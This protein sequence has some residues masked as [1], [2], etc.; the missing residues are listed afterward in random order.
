MTSD[1]VS[2]Q[3]RDD[4]RFLGDNL[5]AVLKSLEGQELFELVEKVRALS[6][7]ARA[8]NAHD[9]KLL[10]GLLASL[11]VDVARPLARAFSHFL[12]LANIAEQHDRVRR[13]HARSGFAAGSAADAFDRLLKAGI[14]PSEIHATVSSLSVDLVLTAHPTQ[15]ARRT[16]LQKHRRIAAALEQRDRPDLT[17]A[18]RTEADESVRREIVA[19]WLTD[20]LRRNKP[21][22]VDEARAGLVLFEQVLWDALPVSLRELDAALIKA[23]GRALP[24]DAAPIKFSSWMGGDRDGNPNVTSV[25]TDEVCVLARWMAA[26]LYLEETRRLYDELSLEACT[27]EVRAIVG[28]VREPYRALLKPLRARLAATKTWCERRVDVLR[29]GGAVTHDV[30][31]AGTHEEANDLLLDPQ[32]MIDTLSLCHRS[33]CDVGASIV[34]AGRL[35]DVLRRLYAFGLVLAPLDVRQDSRV[36]A[37]ALGAVTHAL[38]LGRYDEWPEEKRRAFLL[39]ELSSNRPLIPRHIDDDV[40]GTAELD[41]IMATLAVCKRHGQGSLG[42]YV[43]SMCKAPSD[44]LAVELFM[45]EAQ[46]SQPMRVVPLF[47]TLDDLHRAGATVTALLDV[48]KLSHLEVMIGYSDSAKDAG[49]VASAWALFRAQEDL[50]KICRERNVDLTLFH[51]RG[52]T[53]GRGGGPIYLAILSQPPGSVRGRVRITVQGET[54]EAKLGLPG[55]ALR[56]LELM[57]SATLEATL[58]PPP[59]PRDEWRRVMDRLGEIAA[60]EYRKVL[61]D[62]HFIPYF[63]EAT[64]EAE[65]GRLQIGSRPARRQSK[66]GGIEGLRAIPWIFSWTQTRLMLPSWLGTGEAIQRVIDEGHRDTLEEMARDWPFFR[67]LI[68]L[69]EMVLAKAD[70]GIAAAYDLVLVS[71]RLRPFGED[72]RRR[73]QITTQ[74]LLDI[75]GRKALLEENRTLKRS[76]ELRNPY[77]DPLN[78]LQAE[79]MRRLR[80]N[81]DQRLADAL[82]V[83]VNGVAAG[84]RNTG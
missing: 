61:A 29:G 52:G 20:E 77:V 27:D 60:E 83:T 72:L 6:K 70:P 33:L 62:E 69:L 41:E 80:E 49:R 11:D 65:L 7:G 81:E 63:H 38:G 22:P 36:H 76:I 39:A 44:M 19:D 9:Q 32:E 23:T 15:A 50:V 34:A 58:S 82:L 73:L 16:V 59:A 67:A 42:A 8:G 35:T 55:I 51:G 26:N 74:S 54:V 31:I 84:M 57:T 64:P 56:S 37:R 3:L 68:D 10:R 75:A 28:D 71:E 46:L 14:T 30:E 79:L 40:D 21:T 4:V 17:E 2:H 25:V 43:I 5:G 13:R 47:E 48:R 24:F 78:L 18:E 53:V 1:G 12:A 66:T 45:R